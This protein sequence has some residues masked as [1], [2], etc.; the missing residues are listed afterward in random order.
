MEK[1]NGWLVNY[2]HRP[3]GSYEQHDQYV[4]NT[5]ARMIKFIDKLVAEEKGEHDAV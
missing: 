5:R 4:F 3:K 1:E 2:N